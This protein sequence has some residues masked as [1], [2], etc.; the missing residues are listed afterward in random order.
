M[1][2]SMTEKDAVEI[3]DASL[4]RGLLECR[5]AAVLGECFPAQGRGGQA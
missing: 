3:R 5:A 2:M 4:L 1:K